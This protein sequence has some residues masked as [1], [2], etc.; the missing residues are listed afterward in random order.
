AAGFLQDP[1]RKLVPDEPV[2]VTAVVLVF[3]AATFAAA[4]TRGEIVALKAIPEWSSRMTKP[5]Q[6]F[7]FIV[8][9]QAAVAYLHTGSVVV[10]GIGVLV[11]L[12]PIPAFMLGYSHASTLERMQAFLWIYVGLGAILATGIYFEWMGMDWEIL[13]SV[14]EPL[15]VYS[16]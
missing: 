6:L 14:G 9:A 4:K 10:A 12:A 2:Y 11:Y 1:A 16:S 8:L 15:V 3:A 5:L 7:A 13:H